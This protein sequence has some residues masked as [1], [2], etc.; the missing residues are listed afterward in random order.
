MKNG[1][2]FS[3]DPSALAAA[4]GVLGEQ[5][6]VHLNR[7]AQIL[8]R[9]AASLDRRYLNRL[10]RMGFDAR[11]R[12]ALL[13]ITPGAA[14]QVLSLGRPTADFFEQ[15]E[16]NGRRLAKLNLAPDQVVEALGEYDALL[17]PVFGPLPS[18]ERENLEWAREQLQFCV[19][20][21]LNNAFYHVR[22]VETDAYQDLFR[23]EL[24]SR[25]LDELLPRM[26]EALSKFCRSDA[27]AL[28]LR[29][30][31]SGKWRLR[32]ATEAAVRIEPRL[33]PGKRVPASCRNWCVNQATQGR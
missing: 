25:N 8:D 22:E 33:L 11:Q 17:E 15:V 26:L 32:A 7:L 13:A 30:P 18:L 10:R 19:V 9:H 21:T 28:F 23:A 1:V 31:E 12:K 29:E 4:A 24:E 3:A 14:S 20:L 6:Q 2:P 5:L 27:G 16:Y